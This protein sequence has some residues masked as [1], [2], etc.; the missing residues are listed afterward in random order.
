MLRRRREA[1]NSFYARVLN[2]PEV[3]ASIPWPR[4]PLSLRSG[5]RWPEV[6]TLLRAVADPVCRALL[7]VLA[8]SGLRISGAC[9][10]RV[11]DVQ[12]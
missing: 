2:R 10:L 3:V 9:A 4:I 1:P 8:S 12:S 11:T 6:L 5:P 7:Y